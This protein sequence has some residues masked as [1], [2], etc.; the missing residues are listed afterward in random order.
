METGNGSARGARADRGKPSTNYTGQGANVHVLADKFG[1]LARQLQNEP[2]VDHTLLAIVRAG[3]D[4]VPGAEHASI[5]A[6]IKRREVRTRAATAE[7]ARQVD[8]AQYGT[9]QGPCL[10]ALYEQRSVRLPDTKTEQRWPEFAARALDLGVRS[11]L[12]VQLYVTGENLGALNLHSSH[13][14]AFDDE[15]EQVA[16]LFAAHAAVALAGATTEQHMQ[17]AVDSRDL[18]GQAKGILIERY[19]VTGQE[20]FRLL[21]VA[22]QATNIKLTEVSHYLVE[23]G[24]LAAA[25]RPPVG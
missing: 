23:T 1:E 20:A 14:D 3:T 11:M 5:S 7:L 4:T 16:L 21:V 9:G 24:H 8:Q 19:K 22:S 12:A 17:T 25:R 15:S 2:D 18:I 6:V 13:A 10:D